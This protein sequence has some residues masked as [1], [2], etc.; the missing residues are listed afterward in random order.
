[1][2]SLCAIV[3]ILTINILSLSADPLRV[4]APQEGKVADNDDRWE[5]DYENS[6]NDNYLR[7]NATPSERRQQ[8]DFS[9]G[10]MDPSMKQDSNYYYPDFTHNNYYHY[11]K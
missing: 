1:M 9:R 8:V 11:G 3:M 4:A 6:D 5:R 10:Q 2:K 7:R